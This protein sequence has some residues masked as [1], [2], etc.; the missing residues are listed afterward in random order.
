MNISSIYTRTDKGAR[1]ASADIS[2]AR[3]LRDVLDAIDGSSSVGDLRDRLDHLGEGALDAALNALLL[4]G[5]IR[6]SA[7]GSASPSFPAASGA[8][9]PETASIDGEDSMRKAQALRDKI[10]A[11]RQGSERSTAEGDQPADPG[12]EEQARQ[13]AEAQ[14]KWAAE[15]EASRLAAEQA[16]EE[17]EAQAKR[18]AQEEAAR[19]AAEQARQDAEA[20]AK[21]AAE[22]DAARRAAEQARQEA[23]AQA[24]RAAAEERERREAAEQVQKLADEQSWREAEEKTR[25]AEEARARKKAKASEVVSSADPKALR[26]LGA[27][28][29]VGLVGVVVLGLVTIHL[30]SFNGQIPQFEK[31]LGERFQQ[32][33]KI[34]GLRVSLLPHIHLRLEGV[35]I[36]AAGQIRIAEVK[37]AGAFGNLYSDHKVFRSLDLDSPVVTDEGLGWILFGQG[38]AGNLMFGQVSALNANLDSKNINLP[39]FDAKLEFDDGGSWK[40]IAVD[41]QD[42]NLTVELKPQGKSVKLDVKARVFKI[43]FGSALALDELVAGGTADATGLVITDFKGF[44]YGGTLS[45]NARLKWGESWSLA[46][47]VSAKQLDSSRV[48]PALLRDARVVATASYLM[49]APEGRKLFAAPRLEG[50]FVI[51]RGTLLGVDLGRTLEGRGTR[52]DT[53][54]S[55]LAGS[56]LHENGATQFRQLR[57][58]E[59]AMSASGTAE[60]DADRNVRGRLALELKL[61]GEPR[62]AKL[63]FSGNLKSIEWR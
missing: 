25:R 17:A 10:R 63:A 38:Q 47:E 46:G 28:I 5:F 9:G 43:P 45:G 40:S 57:L 21:R 62:R 11:R 58:S 24:K 4:E 50:S 55:E 15:E 19:R 13:E 36:G 49:Q 26:K 20:Q 42:K 18:A 2:L 29:A 16:R 52:G 23:E 39:T 51:P 34:T 27:L 32:P 41:S 33:V 6:E 30:M 14:A 3:D 48:V 7:A 60:I 22:E 12:F 59:G 53:Q 31:S 54:F 37:A 1:E 35:S 56:F 44:F 8:A 61:S